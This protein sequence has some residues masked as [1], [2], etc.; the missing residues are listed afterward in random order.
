MVTHSNELA[1]RCDR[2]IRLRDGRID[3][4]QAAA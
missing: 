2:V 1:Q 4:A 3:S